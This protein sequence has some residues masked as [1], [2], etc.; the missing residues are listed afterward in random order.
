M[1]MALGGPYYSKF[2]LHCI[3]ALS[4]RHLEADS[5]DNA[6][7]H[8][9]EK[10]LS[11]AKELLIHEIGAT[12]PKIPTIQGLLILSGRQCA[13]GK[14]SEGWLYTGMA[15][16]MMIDLGLHLNFQELMH[17][18]KLTPVELEVRKRLYCSAYI[19]DKSLSLSLGRPPAL[20]LLPPTALHFLDHADDQHAWLPQEYPEYPSTDAHQTT[21]F[22]F[23]CHLG[24]IIELI[25]IP[26]PSRT[27]RETLKQRLSD[28][29]RK[30]QSWYDELPEPL[31]MDPRC[32]VC[33][34]PHILSLNLLYHTLHIILWRPYLNF[35]DTACHA[36]T[37]CVRSAQSVHN[38][39]VVYGRTFQWRKMTY[40]VSYCV[41]TAATVDVH[42]MKSLDTQRRQEATKRLAVSLQI[43]ESESR[44]TPGIRRSIDIIKRQLRTW[45]PSRT[46]EH[47]NSST[48]NTARSELNGQNTRASNLE[49]QE[50]WQRQASSGGPGSAGQQTN[51][52]MQHQVYFDPNNNSW[53]MQQDSVYDINGLGTGY[54]FV[55]TS[56]GFHLPWSFDET[57]D[58]NFFD[59][60]IYG[61]DGA[62]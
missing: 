60:Q 58:F 6:V 35:P 12:K 31:R 36:T 42:E 61:T 41:Y 55:D 39:F 62:V 15:I 5:A 7:A 46:Q 24:A 8:K 13:V 34:P 26:V 18:E 59:A 44:Q 23:F 49:F 11:T 52:H 9:G 56:A 37:V 57:S 51:E 10:F 3:L 27:S 32:E 1:D 38:M 17:L 4:A 47:Q 22:T 16:R 40:L 14:T 45:T 19:W 2:L 30:L 54:G 20:T 21:C 29:E 25:M 48:A 53:N 43:L 33:P 28:I 50:S